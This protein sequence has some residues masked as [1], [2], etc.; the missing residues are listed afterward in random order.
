MLDT[1]GLGLFGL[2]LLALDVY[3][4]VRIVQSEAATIWK[5]LWI[6]LILIFPLL[7]FILWLLL[8]PTRPPDMQ[9]V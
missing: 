3:A 6:L 9:R 2:I 5:V 4:C 7:G 8:G 1:T